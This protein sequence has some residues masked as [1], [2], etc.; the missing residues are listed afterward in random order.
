MRGVVSRQCVPLCLYSTL[1]R[2]LMVRTETLI[3]TKGNKC[4]N[5][6]FP[7]RVQTL[8]KNSI[9]SA[10]EPEPNAAGGR[11]APDN[12][13]PRP[14]SGAE[15][16]TGSVVCSATPFAPG[17]GSEPGER[18][19]LT[20]S[21]GR[22]GERSKSRRASGRVRVFVYWRAR[23]GQVSWTVSGLW[24]TSCVELYMRS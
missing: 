1:S 10:K 8:T 16:H 11:E 17:V 24:R 9:K 13:N 21:R 15:F 12:A 14:R 7:I 4:E 2:R 20:D 23:P 3:A 6:A 22:R 19:A 5:V 18:R